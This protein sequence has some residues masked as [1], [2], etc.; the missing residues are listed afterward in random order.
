M[1]TRLYGFI[2]KHNLLHC[3]QFGLDKKEILWLLLLCFGGKMLKGIE[4]G[5]YSIGVFIDLSK[6][7]DTIN[8]NMLL[9][10]LH[11]LGIRSI[12]NNWLANH[13]QIRK[14]SIMLYLENLN[15][16]SFR[17]CTILQMV[18]PKGLFLVPNY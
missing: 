18:Y 4:G 13:L 8:H 7:F 12:A 10:K 6:D 15:N 1:Q 3:N 14:Q 17:E 11:K 9:K 2:E 5:L 16:L